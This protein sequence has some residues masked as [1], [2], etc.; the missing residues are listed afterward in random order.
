[1]ILARTGI[2]GLALWILVQLSWG[3]TIW[4]SLVRSLRGS[5]PWAG[6]FLF[7]FCYW[8]AFIINAS[9][10]VY[11]EGPMGGIWFWTIYGL[12]LAAVWARKRH[13]ELLSAYA[14][15]YRP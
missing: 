14:N 11:L 2:P 6:V 12:G 10:D 4:L 13:P 5:E 7:L 8:L 15:P 1:M 3:L 9:F